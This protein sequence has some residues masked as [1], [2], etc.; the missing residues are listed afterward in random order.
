MLHRK[1]SAGIPGRATLLLAALLPLAAAQ[2]QTAG[3]PFIARPFSAPATPSGVTPAPVPQQAP[4]F[5]GS[6][7]PSFAAPSA[8]GTLPPFPAPDAGRPPPQTP[9]QNPNPSGV[10]ASAVPAVALTLQQL[11]DIVLQNN[12]ALLS[13]QQVRTT[14]GAAVTTAGAFPNPRL[15]FTG[16][17]QNA[18]IPSSLSGN[19]TTY[20][21]SQL[22]ENPAIRSARI[23]AARFGERGSQFQV[24]VN[25]NELIAQ[26]RLRA[27]E[28]LLRQAEA[29][30][31]AEA[32]GLLEQSRT[33]VQARV[34]SGEAGRYEIIK[35]DAELVLAR[36][37]RQSALLMADQA[38]LALNRLAAGQLPARWTLTDAR[39]VD[40]APLPD[41]ESL[42][43]QAFTSNPELQFLQ[44][45]IDR[46][47]ATVDGARASR[48]PGVEL[49]Y[50]QARDPEVRQN[51]LGVSVQV[52]LFDRRAGPIAEATSE[53]IRARTRL[54][55]RQAELQQQLLSAWKALE[56]A[57]LR[58]DALSQGAVRDSEAAL[59]VAEAAY[60]FGERGILDVLDAQRVLRTVRSDLLEARYQVQS[61]RIELD[62]LAGRLV[63]TP[64]A[65]AADYRP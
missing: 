60:R 25:R 20:G 9:V 49:R 53:L 38:A 55:G 11:T 34:D 41:L 48:W 12:P 5:P 4:A 62:Y 46:A 27:Y 7:S 65:P 44:S 26:I 8:P 47:N 35:A 14:A 43:Q 45:E 10:A 33:R 16:G 54:E 37:R 6:G 13:A 31:A 28:F 57:R 29:G 23:D 30:A 3:T 50:S 21:V 40:N 15:E 24:V 32:L 19:V 58:A 1:D 2:A 61:A 59:R 18:R 63:G 52:P 22:I 17:R 64:S 36:Q 39:L 51:V 42:Q 56:M